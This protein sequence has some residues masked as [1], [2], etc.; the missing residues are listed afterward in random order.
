MSR[1]NIQTPLR[2]SYRD[3]CT[4]LVFHTG[5]GTLIQTGQDPTTMRW[6]RWNRS[7]KLSIWV[8]DRIR[9]DQSFFFFLRKFERR[10]LMGPC[11]GLGAIRALPEGH[12]NVVPISRPKKEKPNETARCARLLTVGSISSPQLLKFQLRGK[13]K[14]S[15]SVRRGSRGIWR[16]RRRR[17]R[18]PLPPL[19]GIRPEPPSQAA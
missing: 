5:P 2:F 3:L 14:R 17:R 1:A 15:L 11:G 18:G 13:R 9:T 6:I 4:F 7:L 19:R 16:G 10:A 12:T 8:L